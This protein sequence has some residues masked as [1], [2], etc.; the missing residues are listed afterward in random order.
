MP[1]KVSTAG[2]YCLDSVLRGG[3]VV[4]RGGWGFGSS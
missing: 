4:L 3:A 2:E 1:L